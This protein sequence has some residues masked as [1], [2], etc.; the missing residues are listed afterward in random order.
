MSDSQGAMPGENVIAR[1]LT[2]RRPG[3]AYATGVGGVGLALAVRLLLAPLLQGQTAFLFFVPAVVLAGAFGGLIPGLVVTS[4][5]LAAA[6]LVGVHSGHA[7]APQAIGALIYV[8]MGLAIA[9]GGELY[10]HLRL[11]IVAANRGL[12]QREA[13]LRSILDT[14]PDAMVVITERGVM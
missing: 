13:H 3:L 10:H 9:V 2:E 11:R 1:I 12:Q 4:L 8:L 6:L 5:G 7:V 14:V